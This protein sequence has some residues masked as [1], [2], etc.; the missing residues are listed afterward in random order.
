[1]A[2]RPRSPRRTVWLKASERPTTARGQV[3][4]QRA[5][6]GVKGERK[7]ERKGRVMYSEAND[8]GSARARGVAELPT[9]MLPLSPPHDGFRAQLTIPDA[10]MCMNFHFGHDE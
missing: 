1:L 9:R 10:T 8:A 7:G 3:R 4:S 5:G 6:A 2:T